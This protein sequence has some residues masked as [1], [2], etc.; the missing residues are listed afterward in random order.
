MTASPYIISAASGAGKTSLVKALLENSQDICVSVSFTTRPP[1]P[2]EVGGKDYNFISVDDFHQRLERGEFLEHAQVFDNYYGTSQVWV[3]QQ[4]KTGMDVILEIDW[5]GAMQARKQLSNATSIFILP[6][7]LEV[8]EQRL[9]DRQT[10]SQE[11]IQ[12][13]MQDAQAEMSHYGEFDFLIFN[14][15][16]DQ[17][18]QELT[19]IIT[20]NR[21]KTPR[22]TEAQGDKLK[23]LLKNTTK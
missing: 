6:P 17:A 8:L 14:D 21:L 5:Q 11:V 19:S 15:N 4:L 3:E 7:S 13:R 10:D 18:L 23:D 22:Q 16:F 1:R 12:R 2:G 20:A 9:Q